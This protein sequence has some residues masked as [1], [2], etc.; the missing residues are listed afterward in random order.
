MFRR[1]FDEDPEPVSNGMEDP[2]E[3]T[4]EIDG[5]ISPQFNPRARSRLTSRAGLSPDQ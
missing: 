5:P 3:S 1:T 4:P 2:D